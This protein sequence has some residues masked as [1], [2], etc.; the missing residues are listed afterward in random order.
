MDD[1]LTFTPITNH[2]EHLQEFYTNLEY[3]YLHINVSF[4][5]II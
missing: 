4:V 2:T 1:A 5:E 3:K